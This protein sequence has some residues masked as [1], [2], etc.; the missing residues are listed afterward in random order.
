MS[1]TTP[2]KPGDDAESAGVGER[3]T[4]A[5][6]TGA[7]PPVASS[8][9][10]SAPGDRKAGDVHGAGEKPSTDPDE[11]PAEPVPATSHVNAAQPADGQPAD[12]GD[13]ESS[14][15][16]VDFGGAPGPVVAPAPVGT[17]VDADAPAAKRPAAFTEPAASAGAG[18][19]MEPATSTEVPI[20]SEPAAISEPVTSPEPVASAEPAASSEPAT[21]PAVAVP[22]APLPPVVVGSAAHGSVSAGPATTADAMAAQTGASAPVGAPYGHLVSPIY[23]SAPLPPKKKSN[24]GYGSLIALVGTVVFAIVYAAVIAA[25]GVLQYS[26]ADFWSDFTNYVASAAFYVP[27]IFFAVAMILLVQIVNRAGWW[28]YIIGGF[29][30]GAVVYFAFVGGAL[31]QH[32]SGLTPDAATRFVDTLWANAFGI[33]GGIAAREVSIW[34]G[35]WLA[36]RGRKLKARNA[37]ARADYERALDAAPTVP[38]P[39]FAAQQP[40]GLGQPT[41]QAEPARTGGDA[42]Q[43]NSAVYPSAGEPVRPGGNIPPTD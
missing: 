19:S 17:P 25:I 15:P 20:S 2:E 12:T 11:P 10:S 16:A 43:Q 29:F 6:G 35:L 31:A 34:T 37:E 42:G 13:P 24:R 40:G 3:T 14:A 41:G 32:A 26:T 21:S 8:D 5:A 23:V 33:A 18:Q 4:A 9:R 1:D 30:V 39:A 22:P 28:V 36:V 7:V 38:A 27:V